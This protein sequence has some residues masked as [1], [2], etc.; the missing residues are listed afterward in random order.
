MNEKKQ[1]EQNIQCE[2]V[3]GE[4]EIQVEATRRA[5]VFKV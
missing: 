4:T 3:K 5:V 1:K 2:E